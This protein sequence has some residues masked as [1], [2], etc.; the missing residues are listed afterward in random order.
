V[1]LE[2]TAGKEKR[3]RL[4]LL[5]SQRYG[6]GSA[7]VL[8]TASTQRWQMSLPVED[9]RHEMFWRQLLHALADQAPQQAWLGSERVAYEDERDVRLQVEL[10]D[11]N[12]DLTRDAQ[13]EVSV[14]PE[15]GATFLANLQPSPTEPGR[16]FANVDAAT[17]G[18]YRAELTARVADKKTGKE[19]VVTAST[20]FRRDD[21]VVEYFDARQHRAVLERVAHETQGRYWRLDQLTELGKAI[22]YTKSGIVE[23]QVLDLWNLPIVFLALLALK[24]GEWLL[25]LKWGTL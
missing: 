9:E 23:R 16:Y 6:R 2:A 18:L 12:F 3:E 11:H 21:N 4:P 8:A 14:T 13:V 22:P 25:R 5:I 10:R 7:F 19:Q 1:L 17:P 15:H 24:L 20:A